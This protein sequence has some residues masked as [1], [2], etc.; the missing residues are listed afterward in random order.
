MAGERLS[1]A[2]YLFEGEFFNDAVSRAYYSMFY[3]AKALLALKDIYPKAHK[4]VVSKFGLEFVKEGF[5]EDI[6]GRAFVHAKDRREA[7]EYDIEKRISREEAESI[8]DDADRFLER[9]KRAIDESKT[10]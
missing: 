8:I 1:A 5:I 3:A 6:Y 10:N 9:M 4:G 2:K 7:A